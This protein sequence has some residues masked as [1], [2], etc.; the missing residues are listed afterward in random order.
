MRWRTDFAGCESCKTKA[1][2]L[3]VRAAGKWI[4]RACV[5]EMA[6]AL[7]EVVAEMEETIAAMEPKPHLRLVPKPEPGS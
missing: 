7:D 2:V 3:C 1:T 5:L 4:C 6:A